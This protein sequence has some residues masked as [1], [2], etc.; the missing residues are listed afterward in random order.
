MRIRQTLVG[1]AL[2]A[3]LAAIPAFSQP[4]APAAEIVSLEGKGEYRQPQQA[5]WSTA[6]APQPL[7]ADE[8]VR[9][10][11]L[12]KMSILFGDRTRHVLSP[13][14]T[15]Q[16]KGAAAPDGRT[17]IELNKGRAW[18]AA[19]GTPRGLTI[20]T[21]SATAAIRGTEW[22]IAV[23]DDGRATL[24]VFSGEV[25]FFNDQGRVVVNA[26]EQA[27]AERGKAP[28]KL[29]LRVSRERVQ[30]VSSSSV[31]ANRYATRSEVPEVA[32]LMDE[33]RLAEAY[34][35]LKESVA[36]GGPASAFLQLADFEIYRGEL[37]AADSVLKQA[38][39]RYPADERFDVARARVAL[40]DDRPGALALAKA[41]VAK[42]D[43]SVD[44]W[45][46][47]G[48][49][50]R[51][52]GHA[53]EALAAYA[54][55]AQLASKDARPWYGLG[56]VESERQNVRTAR[57]YLEKA[58]EL[59]PKEAAALAELG[60]LEGFAGDHGR[61]RESLRKA[62]ALDATN[63][64][65]WTGLGVVELRDGNVEAAADALARAI[66]IEPRYARAHLYFAAA[67]YRLAGDAAA[68]E[69]L[70]RASE[71]DP[72]DPLPH[73]LASM[74][75]LDRIEPGAA[76]QAANRAVER[77]PYLKSLNPVATDQRG[78]A[79]AGYPLGNLGLEAWARSIAQES[80]LPSWGASHFFLADRYPGDFNRRSE[81]VQGFITDP[82][83][84]GAS[85]RFQEL[86]VQPGH[87]ATLAIRADTSD[88]W[89]TYEPVL[90]LNGNGAGAV[91][92]AYF[93]EVGESTTHA[94][95]QLLDG[96]IRRFTG[97]FGF[98][99][100]HELGGF[101]Y[102]NYFKPDIET[103][104]VLGDSTGS[105]AS[106]NRLSGTSSRV[107][108]GVSYAPDTRARFWLKGGVGDEDSASDFVT[109]IQVP[110]ITLEQ[111]GHYALKPRTS[112]ASFRALYDWDDRLELSAGAQHS[113]YDNPS[114]LAQD[115]TFHDP[116]QGVLRDHLRQDD[117]DRSDSIHALAR[118][119]APAFRVEG[120]LEWHEFR[121]DRTSVVSRDAF[122]GQ[123]V[124]LVEE[125][126]RRKADPMLGIV[127]PV[128]SSSLVRV[129]CRR[130]VRPWASDTLMPVAVA[131]VPLADQLVLPGGELEQCRAQG[132]WTFANRAFAMASVERIETSN[133]LLLAGV[134]N[135][136]P[137]QTNLDRLRNRIVPQPTKPDQLEDDPVYG[138]G[139]IRR[140]SLALEAKVLPTLAARLYYT[141][142]DSE[143][144]TQ[145]FEGLK[146][147]LLPRHQTNVG[148]TWTPG[149]HSLLTVQAIH[150]TTRY[151]DEVNS[152]KLP[153]SWDGQ[154]V[155]F[156]ETPDK[157]WSIEARALSLLKKE[158]SDAFGVI[159][160][161]RF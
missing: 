112:D 147:P 61:A 3:G 108:A 111:G 79:N 25:E 66:A 81:L 126:R 34:A 63:Y 161:Y 128:G 94:G 143:N 160:S 41:A 51:H 50:E 27:A 91:P 136:R 52:E 142:T 53:R 134:A 89:S 68:L 121:K 35:R 31:D 47:L 115:A 7:F 67:Q 65:A 96:T 152:I 130:W 36:A 154:V 131:G 87:Y 133:I 21:P 145:Y 23:D 59:D 9:T 48:D 109:R 118:Y 104:I 92:Y 132:E 102:V 78:I 84:F 71:L 125:F 99:P 113:G 40:F 88:D 57:S 83:S 26:N 149:W 28:V 6:K 105:V 90:T 146:V 106:I 110:A 98:K 64:V 127:A 22:E 75:Y 13:N 117:R 123:D 73:L 10:L 32:R 93:A 138:G 45:L 139:V 148:F 37:G 151:F 156:V 58:I 5:A 114:S 159:L 2:A 44:A 12:S 107:D 150:R 14:S 116:S 124:T 8:F 30:W 80:Y 16:I 55:A 137:D 85:N 95:N 4:R 33:Q 72:N 144:N 103:G 77:M 155:I 119:R 1:L 19:K 62:L 38:Q 157:H 122:P 42:R 11:D 43:N 101:V 129:A 153:A 76:S 97:G 140:A 17:T 20:E 70:Q 15:M 141:Y 120:G 39:A 56:V 135:Q 18:G 29:Q 158:A 82:L 86:F 24:S 46:A 69:E 74:V 49:I 60:T 54:R 100:T